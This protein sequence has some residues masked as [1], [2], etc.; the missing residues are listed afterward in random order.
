MA[1]T[2]PDCSFDVCRLDLAAIEDDLA[3]RTDE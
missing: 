2:A 3:S 1:R